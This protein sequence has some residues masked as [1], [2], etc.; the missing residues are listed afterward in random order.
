MATRQRKENVGNELH[1][2]GSGVVPAV[3]PSVL[4]TT[5]K[6]TPLDN[7]VEIVVSSS[8]QV[9]LGNYENKSSFTSA[10][11]RFAADGDQE[12]QI[13]YLWDRV[14]AALA[15]EL[16]MAASL[17]TLSSGRRSDKEGTFIHLIVSD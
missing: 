11:A 14:Y 4:S 6:V 12:E 7:E 2:E 3:E 15:P 13:A 8:F 10:K 9:N 17:T 16:E 1:D 5:A